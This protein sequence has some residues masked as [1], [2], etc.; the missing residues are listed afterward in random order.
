VSPPHAWELC[1]SDW[2]YGLGH[3]LH[4]HQAK[5]SGVLN[6]LDYDIWRSAI[7]GNWRT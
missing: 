4:V 2:S 6:G 5:F 1:H 7:M 3:T